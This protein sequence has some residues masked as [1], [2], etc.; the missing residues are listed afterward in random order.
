MFPSGG[1]L[2]LLTT[3]LEV[4]NGDAKPKR[5]KRRKSSSEAWKREPWL[6]C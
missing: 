6:L 5:M 4:Y 1:A 2:K 3:N